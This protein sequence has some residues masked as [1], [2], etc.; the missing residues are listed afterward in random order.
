M[1][2][3]DLTAREIRNLFDQ[4]LIQHVERLVGTSDGIGTLPLSCETI[5]CLILLTERENEIENFGLDPSERYTQETF[6]DELAEMGLESDGDLK[7]ALQEMTQ[8]GYTRVD[9]DGRFSPE[10][11]TTSAAHLLD[12]IFPGMPGMNLVAYLIQTMDEVQSGRKDLEFAISQFD[13]TLE[14]KGVSLKKEKTSPGPD[15]ALKPPVKRVTSLKKIRL[16]RIPR[17][18]SKILSFSDHSARKEIKAVHF[19]ELLSKQ[20]E[21]LESSPGICEED[22]A[23]K[24]EMEADEKREA[25]GEQ[26][27]TED[28]CAEPEIPSGT[29]QKI[30]SEPG[31]ETVDLAGEEDLVLSQD[32]EK[33][34]G[35]ENIPE[36]HVPD[37]ADDIIEKRIA[38]FEEDLAMQC[39]ICKSGNIQ[40]TE[41]ATGKVYYNCSNKNCNFV[42]WGK[43]YHLV[44]PQCNN[45]FLVETLDRDGKKIIKCPRATCR[46]RQKSPLEIAD[47]QREKAGSPSKEPAK[48]PVISRKP[49]KRVVRRRV[50]RRKR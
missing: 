20:D 10:K 36:E 34:Y 22:E 33:E 44:C 28:V 9:A 7:K 16:P 17:S 5:S 47:E 30:P 40:A 14:M 12:S 45:P 27:K 50:V 21:S 6:F 29:L 26:N 35:T 38:A 49:R 11:P 1:K 23:Q 4:A 31:A 25:P 24:L 15:K 8:K 37:N 19:G 42:S 41:T 3:N 18:E 48:K 13:Q 32:E 2:Q 43:P 39:P 46:Y